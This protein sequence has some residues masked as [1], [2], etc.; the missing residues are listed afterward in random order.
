MT[1]MLQSKEIAIQTCMHSVLMQ[2]KLFACRNS[3]AYFQL[4]KIF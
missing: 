1:N 4:Y 2:N 3:Y